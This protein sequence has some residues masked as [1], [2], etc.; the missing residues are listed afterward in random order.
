[1]C[2]CPATEPAPAVTDGTPLARLRAFITHHPLYHMERKREV[3]VPTSS[4]ALDAKNH[5]A[6]AAVRGEAHSAVGRR[7]RA[8][9]ACPAGH[10]GG[11]LRYRGD[12]DRH[13]TW[14]RP[15]GRLS[16]DEVV[17]FHTNLVLRGC[18]SPGM[19]APATPLRLRAGRRP[20]SPAI[21][22][23]GRK[24]DALPSPRLGLDS[25]QPQEPTTRQE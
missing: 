15:D 24:S 2:R 10:P 14:Y 18:V 1:M 23:T 12:A 9:L 8:K 3:Y 20:R 16:K 25:R 5:R 11:W 19:S 13:R 4:C 21:A 6:E 22:E 7:C 17:R